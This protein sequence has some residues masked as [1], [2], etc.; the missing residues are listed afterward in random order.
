M[1]FFESIYR[2]FGWWVI[3][4][5]SFFLVLLFLGAGLMAIQRKVWGK[6]FLIISCLGFAFLGVI[7]IG[8]WMIEALENRF[9]KI[10]Q[11]PSDTK[12]IIL[13]GGSFDQA[14]TQGRGETAYNPAAGRFI[15]FVEVAKESPHLQPVFTGT[16][17]EVETA[18]R[19]F[20]A[21]G[22]DPSRVLFEGTS[23]D[24]KDNALKTAALLNSKAGEKWVLVTSAYHMPRSVGLF[25]KAGFDVIPY[26][27]DYH[28]SGQ[29]RMGFSFGLK[30]NLEAWQASSREWLGMVINY[31]MGRSDDL[32]P[33][34]L[35]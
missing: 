2:S 23:K 5:D 1:T 29:E 4:I 33:G 21:L 13:L 11:F 12:G 26:P 17:F 34:K 35:T 30:R 16:P 6:R 14:V 18:K 3:N 28:T 8:V 24:T 7:P 25:R 9:P 22:L 15:Q 32:Y 19:E 27:D 31:L 20:E 10:H